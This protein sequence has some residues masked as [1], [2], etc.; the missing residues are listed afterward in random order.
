MKEKA[1]QLFSKT[2]FWVEILA[3]PFIFISVWLMYTE[4]VTHLPEI[5]GIEH[6]EETLATHENEEE[7]EEEHNHSLFSLAGLIA[8]ALLAISILIWNKTKMHNYIPCSAHG[9]HISTTTLTIVSILFV[10]HLSLDH[11]LAESAS[12][13]NQLAYYTHKVADIFALLLLIINWSRLT[14][15]LWLPAIVLVPLSIIFNFFLQFH[16]EDYNLGET[17]HIILA[18]ALAFFLSSF[19]HK[20]GRHNH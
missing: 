1:K 2:L 18:F 10:A 5:V 4:T 7:H 6:N 17:G 16:P 20:P 8:L 11:V 13:I 9:H 12:L 19:L 3:L 15:N 14:K